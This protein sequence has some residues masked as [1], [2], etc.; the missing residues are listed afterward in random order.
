[1]CPLE[2][3]N[4]QT[5]DI[6]VTLKDDRDHQYLNPSS[7][8]LVQRLTPKGK[9][10]HTY[11]L[12]ED[13]TTRLFTLAS[14]TAENGNADI[15]VI[16]LTS[17]NMGGIIVLN[18]DEL[19]RAIYRGLEGS[20][21]HSSDEACDSKRRIVVSEFTNKSLHLLGSDR[22]FYRY[23]LSYMFDYLM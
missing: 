6:L 4:S 18:V 16:N 19:V 13:G 17:K 21:F 7:R 15:C 9:V 10:L 23:L 5:D 20:K 11:E 8:R 3:S 2:I 14:R 12:R 1:M 22:S